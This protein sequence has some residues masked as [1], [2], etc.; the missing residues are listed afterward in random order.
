MLDQEN[1]TPAAG[2]QAGLSAG[3]THHDKSKGPSVMHPSTYL[4]RNK[5]GY[6]EI[7]WPGKR[8][9]GD[10]GGEGFSTKTRDEAVARRMKAEYDRQIAAETPEAF[11]APTTADCISRYLV[12]A[13]HRRVHGSQIRMLR[14]WLRDPLSG[15]LPRE[16]GGRLLRD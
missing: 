16:L 13:Q 1:P 8:A 2:W 6:W 4:A 7:R 9:N 10:P 14:R 11:I 12:D 3:A 15:L 5:R